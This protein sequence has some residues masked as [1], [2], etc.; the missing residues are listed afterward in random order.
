MNRTTDVSP[1]ITRG[2]EWF[3]NNF[4]CLLKKTGRIFT[5]SE[6]IIKKCLNQLKEAKESGNL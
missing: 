6:R 1:R 4:R 5:R 3:K 2:I